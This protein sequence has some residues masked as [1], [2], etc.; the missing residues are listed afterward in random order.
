MIRLV[1][2]IYKS[3]GENMTKRPESSVLEIKER[4]KSE[5]EDIR[6]AE[7]AIDYLTRIKLRRDQHKSE[8]FFWT[9]DLPEHI[10]NF[11]YESEENKDFFR[12]V[13]YI[14]RELSLR[15]SCLDEAKKC[16]A[17]Y[18]KDLKEAEKWE[19][20]HVKVWVDDALKDTGL[21]EIK[22]KDLIGQ[23]DLS[24]IVEVTCYE[25][26]GDNVVPVKKLFRRG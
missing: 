3:Y 1:I 2:T 14:P 24:N 19:K 6:Q 12:Y 7:L 22:S 11:I 8:V 5:E 15:E 4:I 18:K 21:K 20:A 10:E 16:L 23:D 9:D 17:L 13:I 25:Q 26:D